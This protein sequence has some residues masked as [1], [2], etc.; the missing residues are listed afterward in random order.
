[1]PETDAPADLKQLDLSAVEE[2]A[3]WGFRLL[4]DPA[5]ILD[6]EQIESTTETVD[7]SEVVRVNGTEVQAGR[8]RFRSVSGSRRIPA[9]P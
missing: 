2:T 9:F 6:L 4:V 5:L 8:Q 7:G 1:M 3:R